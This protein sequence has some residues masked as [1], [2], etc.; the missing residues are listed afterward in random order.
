MTNKDYYIKLSARIDES[1]K[2]VSDLNKQITSLQNKVKDL[3]IKVSVPSSANKGFGTLNTQ[4]KDLGISMKDFK[5]NVLSVNKTFDT[6]TTKYTDNAGKILTVTEKIIDGHKRYKLTLK[7]TNKELQKVQSQDTGFVSLDDQLKSLDINM[8]NFKNNVVSIDSVM[9]TTTTKYT[10]NA[11]KMLTITEK[12]VD[13]QKQYKVALKDVLTTVSGTQQVAGFG[14]LDEQLRELN[15]DMSAFKKNVLSTNSTVDSTTTRYTDNAGKMLTITE[16]LV[17][18]QKQ[19]KVVLKEVN[20]AVE[21][22]AKQ[23][24][25]WNYSWSK[26][27]QSFVTYMTV[28]KVFY[29]IVNAIKDMISVVTELDSSLVELK[30]VTDLEGES[31]EKF[32]AQAY[33]AG[34]QVAKTGQEMIE[35]ATSFAKAG[36][37]ED[38]ILGLGEVAS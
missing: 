26:A 33:E 15:V 28:T 32:T 38:Q 16:K 3:E 12:L 25:K 36:Y 22:N 9:G 37:S 31:L 30:K 2:S 7:E 34:A 11:G 23:A 13:G 14:S 24:D 21:S 18:G 6:T 19:Y 35:A 20:S 29:G 5:N 1:Q 27:F 8:S 4:L 17:N 10:D